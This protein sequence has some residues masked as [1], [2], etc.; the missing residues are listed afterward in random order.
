MREDT[1]YIAV[2][3]HGE[4][5]QKR[6][7]AARTLLDYAFAN[8]TLLRPDESVLPRVRV[9]LGTADSVGV[10]CADSGLIVADKRLRSRLETAAELPGEIEAPVAEGQ[11]LGTLR[12]TADGKVISETPLVAEADVLRKGPGRIWLELVGAL[13]GEK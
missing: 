11:R 7:D 8:Y 5:S 1:E 6:F 3:L 2:I 13:C 4:T 12:L 9:R 10:R